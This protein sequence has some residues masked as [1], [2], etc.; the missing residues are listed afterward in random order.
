MEAGGDC[1]DL[2]LEAGDF[3]AALCDLNRAGAAWIAREVPFA[4][5]QI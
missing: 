5:E 4:L 3:E 1:G 2:H